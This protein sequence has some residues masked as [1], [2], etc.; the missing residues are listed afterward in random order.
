[1]GDL[2]IR[3]ALCL[4]RR[5]HCCFIEPTLELRTSCLGFL[6]LCAGLLDLPSCL[7]DLRTQIG[8]LLVTFSQHLIALGKLSFAVLYARRG[9]LGGGPGL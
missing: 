2:E 3:V 9:D 8:D 6:C 4:L 1:M 7:G 5:L